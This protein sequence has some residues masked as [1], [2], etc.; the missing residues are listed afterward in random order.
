MLSDAVQ[1]L[2]NK[3][4]KHELYSAYLYLSMAAYFESLSLGGCA[5]WMRLQ[6]KEEL[7]HSLKLFDFIT[8]R[9]GRIVLE[10]IDQPPGEFGSPLEVF[11]Q[12]LAHE[13]HV[14]RLIYGIYEAAVAE[15][16][17]ATQTMLHWFIDEQVEEEKSASSLVDLL[18]L[19]GDHGAALIML[20]RQLHTRRGD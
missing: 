19:S 11:Q 2:L 13:R 10:A 14:T 17:Y 4:I 9:G 1:N 16:D 5:H 20:D 8:D 7:E 15:H 3:Q 6:G 12:A 18:K